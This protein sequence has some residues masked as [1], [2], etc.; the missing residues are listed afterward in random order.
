MNDLEQSAADSPVIF[1]TLIHTREHYYGK[2]FCRTMAA[3]PVLVW[4]PDPDDF[5]NPGIK[6]SFSTDD[7]ST[8]IIFINNHC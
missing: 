2:L 3:G 1:S 7:A 8:E 4:L 5:T 6:P